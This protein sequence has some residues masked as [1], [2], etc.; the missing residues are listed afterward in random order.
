MSTVRNPLEFTM[1]AFPVTFQ[2]PFDSHSISTGV[3]ALYVHVSIEIELVWK[4]VSA[5]SAILA[6]RSFLKQQLSLSK[7]V[8]HSYSYL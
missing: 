1:L 4:L 6:G 8:N 3:A 7:L 2:T 5:V